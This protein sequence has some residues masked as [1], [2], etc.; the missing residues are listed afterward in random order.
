V[1][2][3]KLR[4]ATLA[5]TMVVAAV[6]ATPVPAHAAAGV[7]ANCYGDVVASLPLVDR[8]GLGART[9]LG[10]VRLD[11]Y[12]SEAAGG[13]T[14]VM[15]VGGNGTASGPLPMLAM[16][17]T[18]D[19]RGALDR[20]EYRYHAA[21]TATQTAG[22]CIV[23]HGAATLQPFGPDGAPGDAYFLPADGREHCNTGG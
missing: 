5:A 7:A 13:T 9:E 19:G 17:L 12:Y 3:V 8:D 10:Q 2:R 11:V 15:T 1:A 23:V 16:L 22:E 4:A 18:A 21:V 14:C 6:I 20:G